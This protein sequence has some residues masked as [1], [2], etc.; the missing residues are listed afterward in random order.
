MSN[1]IRR[2][3][4]LK[5]FIGPACTGL[6]M[7]T[8]LGN[9]TS[10]RLISDVE[11][12]SPNL[13]QVIR[14][15][16][17][18]LGTFL[19]LKEKATLEQRLAP[20]GITVEWIEFSAGLPILEAMGNNR[21]DIGNGGV[22][23]P[24]VSQ[25]KGLP[26]VYVANDTPVP[27]SIGLIVRQES[28]IQTLADLKGKTISAAKGSAGH[29]LLVRALIKGNLT[30]ND[31]TFV[32][33]P[34]PDGKSAFEQGEIDALVLWQPFLAQLQQTMPIRFLST[35][36]GLMNDR[37]FYFARQAFAYQYPG[38]LQIVMDEARKIGI[39]AMAN[40]AEAADILVARTGLNPELAIA[41]T[42]ARRYDV[43]PLQDRAI[44]EQQRIAET[45]FRLGLLPHRIWVE[46]AVWKQ[47][48]SS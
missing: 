20:L 6:G 35:A 4:F 13:I 40:P 36:D 32:D 45:F 19:Y 28:S 43:L 30:L 24:V 3:N 42:Q 1:L 37:N 23:P 46:D 16:H 41:V 31:I 48:L 15:A 22:V 8:L 18:P 2:R 34:P 44:E 47:G 29:Y 7:S 26:F 10:F 21:V 27:D 33:L 14:V 5:H 11:D 25:A 39:W 12:T 9:C 17:Q 38:L